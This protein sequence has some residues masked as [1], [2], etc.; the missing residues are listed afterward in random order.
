M[1]PKVY[2]PTNRLRKETIALISK[3]AMYPQPL[4]SL[5]AQKF[6][7]FTYKVGVRMQQSN[8]TRPTN[9]AP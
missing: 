8:S 4:V 3:I 2:I 9:V 1:Q 6:L 7:C 5:R